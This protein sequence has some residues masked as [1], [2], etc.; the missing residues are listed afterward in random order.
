M[1]VEAD[2]P[3]ALAARL[4][5]VRAGGS[6][7]GRA[8]D[9]VSAEVPVEISFDG[10]AFAVM[11]ASPA[12]LED[13]ACG[14]A[15]TEAGIEDLAAIQAI[16]VQHR[17]EGIQLDIRLVGQAAM[18]FAERLLPGRS[19]CGLCGSRTLEDVVRQ[20]AM[21]ESGP[22]MTH[23]ALDRALA[24]LHDA[25][26]AGQLTGSLHAA[27]WFSIQGELRLVRED[28]GRHNALDKLLGSLWRQGLSMDEGFLVVTSR[29]SY[30]MVTK[31]ATAGIAIMAAISAPTALA[32][33]LADSCGLTLIGFARPGR[34]L[35]YSHEHRF[36]DTPEFDSPPA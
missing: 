9:W 11:M 36:L 23:A 10:Q 1:P 2:C 16:T 5:V 20:P 15:R 6:H 4:E 35:I 8:R 24:V 34:C 26:P 32:V 14:F 30:E 12:D 17:L 25:Q 21:I 33:R 3:E 28:I 22:V 27:A 19:G 13:F 7:S 29:A 31:A 18:A